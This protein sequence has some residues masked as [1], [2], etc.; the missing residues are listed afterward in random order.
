MKHGQEPPLRW[1]VFADFS[2]AELYDLLRFRQGIFVVEQASPYADLDGIDF[3]ARHLLARAE[4]E[5]A[6]CLR[7]YR[8][9]RQTHIG[10]LAVART[11]RGRGLGRR[12]MSE[13]LAL[14]WRE[15]PGDPIVLGAQTYL[16]RFYE[17]FGFV[18]ASA[19][20]DDAGV[21]HI[22]MVRA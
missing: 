22:D 11:W 21:P 13:A 8:R 15:F 3:E 12:V 20:Y 14:C 19:A 6:G 7:L 18:A 16:Q 5:L 10:R 2:A 1:Q 4:R 17:S 9:D